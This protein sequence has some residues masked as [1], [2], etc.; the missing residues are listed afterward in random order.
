MTILIDARPLCL[1]SPGGV[2][3]LAKQLLDELFTADQN[4]HYV[5]GTTG[6]EKPILP[7]VS[8]KQHEHKH[9]RVPNKLVSGL[10]TLNLVSFE[11]WM[12]PIKADVLFL[13]NIGFIGTPRLP[14]VLLVHDLT[15]L[16]E[17]RWYSLHGRLWHKAVHAIDLLKRATHLITASAYVKAE[18][19]RQLDI[20]AERIS[21]LSYSPQPIGFLKELPPTLE[22]K[23]Y[24]L[25]LGARDLRKNAMATVRAWEI[26][27]REK[28]FAD[29]ELVLVGG[30]PHEIFED[31]SGLHCFKR[32]T[33]DALATL[34]KHAAVFSYPSWAEGY[35]IPLH[36]AARFQ[37][38]CIASS[39]SALEET[40]PKGTIFVPPEKPHLL[41]EAL[42]LQLLQP[43]PTIVRPAPPTT[44]GA[45]LL[46]VLTQDSGR[47]PCAPTR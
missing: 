22:R 43:Q 3:R 35:G 23:R 25:A 2:T 19:Q 39:G 7:W 36:E 28:I 37:T 30:H 15:F 40:A 20:P 16:T 27:R 11:H 4:N 9:R 26:I 42:R 46:S 5:L 8:D 10:A 1:R 12:H 29:V 38:P 21:I 14:Y 41:A 47:M 6:Y 32:P 44:A 13:P 31:V 24:I 33:D 34:Y 17:P 45:Q 18:L